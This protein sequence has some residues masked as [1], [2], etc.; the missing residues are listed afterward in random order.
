[1]RG[2]TITFTVTDKRGKTSK[3]IPLYQYDYGQKLVFEGVELPEYYEVH[4][5]NEMYGEAVTVL[6]DSTGV[7]IPDTLLATGEPIY[8]WL[9]LH[10]SSY[11]GETEYQGVIPIIKRAEP[12]DVTPTPEEQSII[13]EVIAALNNMED[14]MSEQVEAAETARDAAETA[15]AAAES[16][17]TT[18]SSASDAAGTAQTAAETAQT[19]AEAAQTAAEAA[20]TAAES[21]YANADDARAAAVNAKTAAETAQTAAE[22]ASSTASSAS[23]TA[24]NAASSAETYKTDAQT[25][26][27]AAETAQGL[28]ETAQT[29]AE[30][31]EDNAEASALVAEGYAVGKQDGEAVSSGTYYQ[32]NAAYYAGEA[33]DSATAAASSES[34]AE[35]AASDAEAYAVGKRGGVDV[36]SDDPA[37]HNNAKYYSDSMIGKADMVANAVEGNFAGLDDDGNLVDSGSKPSDFLTEHQDISGKLDAPLA[38]G[39]EGQ[40]LTSDG[41]GGQTWADPS[42]AIDDTA[43]EGDT[44]VT[45][46]ADKLTEEF[47]DVLSGI[48]GVDDSVDD[49]L[50]HETYTEGGSSEYDPVAVYNTISG[51]YININSYNYAYISTPSTVN[52]KVYQI[53]AGKTY[54]V[55]G[56]GKTDRPIYIA[57]DN[58]VTTSGTIAEA[59]EFDYVFGSGSSLAVEEKTYVSTRNGY[60]YITYSSDECGLWV[61]N[62]SQVTKYHIDDVLYDL[63]GIN[64][65]MDKVIRTKTD[66]T[67]ALTKIVPRNADSI[68]KLSNLANTVT[69]VRSIL[70]KN[71]ADKN[72]VGDVVIDSNGTTKKGI[73]TVM[74]P[75][76]R[77]YIA[78]GSMGP[79]TMVKKYEN[80]V[81]SD[82]MY[83]DQFPMKVGVTDPAG[84]CF[85]VYAGSVS[86]LGDMSGLFIGKLGDG[87]QTMTFEAY[88]EKTYTPQDIASD[89]RIE[90]APNGIL[91]FVNSG[92]TAVASTVEYT[93]FGKDD[94]TTTRKDFITSPDGTKFLPMIKNDGS[95]VGARVIPKK[96]F[97]I[98]NSLTSGWQ[99]FG[100]AATESDK[101]FVARFGDVV[102]DLDSDYTFSRKWSTNFEQQTS[103]A[104]AQ[105]WVTTN[106]D[107]LLS[108]DLDLIVVQLSEN[109]VSNASAVATFPES[110]LWLL[111]HLRTECPKARV[112]WMGVWFDRGWVKTLLDNT[113]NTGCEYVDIRPLYLPENVSVLGTV[114]EMESDYTKEYTVDS[115]T[116][117]NGQITLVFTVDGVQYTATIPSYT[118]YTSSSDTSITVTG[119]YHVVS[120]YYAA[121]HPGD[122]GFR[123][124]ANKLLFDLGISD[125]EE[126]I[127]ADS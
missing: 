60:L 87:E 7:L 5:S 49:I 71:V 54:K 88:A 106:I 84:A 24:T 82:V 81:Y 91:E 121:I 57:A 35:D 110:S 3:T 30:A 107:P 40:V 48:Q 27:T 33:S 42:G 101:D 112:V 36:S 111:Q 21:A 102:S 104:N 72:A 126:T 43:G 98:G 125:S 31:A 4:F 76:G 68:A 108:D 119:I 29:A 79:Y 65:Y 61:Q 70:S 32:N 77:Y 50:D 52:V 123:K 69:L 15:Q 113:A 97:F 16:A 92:N 12:T 103:L 115:F 89:N 44:D 63:Q 2:R 73:K 66:S 96:A 17:A 117:D 9:F 41:E 10:D 95:I 6:G 11:D 28:A 114:Y 64:A 99:T 58:A 86:S 74:V 109:V 124:I 93:V 83:Q 8:V 1:M 67:S 25:A 78:L 38:A 62:T 53:E 116:V 55:K 100:E 80:G 13:T 51:A 14:D 45:W 23:G 56:R 118:S 47:G 105:S 34:D 90:V 39:T 18:A 22:S 20:Q 75:A 127:P 46:S 37:Y 59:N 122:E 26:K 85:I 120:T 19:A 94:D